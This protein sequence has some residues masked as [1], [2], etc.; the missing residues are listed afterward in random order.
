M[1]FVSGENGRT[2]EK[3]PNQTPI[4]PSRN[5]TE[6]LR[7][8]LGILVM[9]GERLIA[10]ATEPPSKVLILENVNLLLG[11]RTKVL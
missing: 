4:R 7:R 8:E 1:K 9:E 3:K 2:P 10:Y 11:E 6:W 5:D